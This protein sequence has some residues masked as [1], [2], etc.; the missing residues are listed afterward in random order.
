MIASLFIVAA[1]YFLIF[2]AGKLAERALKTAAGVAL[3]LTI[4]TSW[5]SS[6]RTDAGASVSDGWLRDALL[7]L[8]FAGLGVFAWRSRAAFARRRDA[9]RQRW[10]APRD[11]AMPP[12]PAASAPGDEEPLP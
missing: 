7:L 12:A 1:G 8:A 9:E 3:I 5:V 10:S 11:R 2:G 6:C 4:T